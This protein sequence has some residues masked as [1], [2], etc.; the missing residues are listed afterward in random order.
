VAGGAVPESQVARSPE[1]P[2]FEQ[3]LDE[4]ESVVE[5]LEQGDLPLDEAL[6]AFERGV[7][8]TRHCHNA[9][10]AAQQRVEI[11]LQRG[12]QAAV[13]PFTVTDEDPA[14]PSSNV[15]GSES[16]AVGS[17]AGGTAAGT[18]AQQ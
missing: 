1:P 16:S 17:A 5:R 11:L 7:E 10:K 13:E 2:E 12:G 18:P 6:R 15:P 14:A 4:L 9:L 3:A 8:L